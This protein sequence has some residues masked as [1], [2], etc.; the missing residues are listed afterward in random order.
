MAHWFMLW[1]FQ[2]FQLIMFA[3]RFTMYNAFSITFASEGVM[4]L[5]LGVIHLHL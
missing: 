2:S 4:N 5:N 1:A 3:I